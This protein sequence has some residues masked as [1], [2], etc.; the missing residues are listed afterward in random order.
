[1][2]GIITIVIIILL[3]K[4]YKFEIYYKSN[5]LTKML[6]LSGLINWLTSVFGFFAIHYITLSDYTVI[7]HS[8]PIITSILEILFLKEKLSLTLVKSIFLGITGIF[9]IAKPSFLFND[10]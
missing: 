6:F 4:L 5:Y 1:M 7:I 9:L 2:R 8:S 3:A 10:L